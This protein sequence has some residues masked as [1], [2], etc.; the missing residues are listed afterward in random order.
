MRPLILLALLVGLVAP[1]RAADIVAPAR[2]ADLKVATWNLD[3]FTARPTGD[4]AL[5]PDVRRRTQADFDRLRDYAA[6]LAPDVIALEEVDGPDLAA[7]LFPGY[8]IHFTADTVVQR[9]G[10]AVRPGLAIRALPDLTDLDV[11]GRS[12][13]H[14]RS[15]ADID[16][17]WAGQHL[18][19]LAVHLKT[20]CQRARLDSARSR[21]CAVLRAQ[22]PALQGW[23]AERARA[24]DPFILLGDF[25][26]V[27]DPPDLLLQSLRRV[28]PLARATEGQNDPCWGG[29][30]F[31]DHILAGGSARG[32]M[33]AD[34]LRVMVFKETDRARADA[35]SD[36][37]AVSVR[38]A[39]P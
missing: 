29:G 3:W 1:A 14:L 17:S 18:R 10:F 11:P 16:L 21:D 2:A 34:S 19:L 30:S 8:Q 22:I 24:G 13:H 7:W 37:C 33:R 12:F 4:P 25:N 23:I 26:R 32:W 9:V 31:I 6:A 39:I 38:L 20:G 35:L 36:H 28:A 15:G 27:M 5:P